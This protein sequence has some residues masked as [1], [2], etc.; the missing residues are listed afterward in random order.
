MR[1]RGRA[2]RIGGMALLDER[3]PGPALPPGDTA[4]TRTGSRR[5]PGRDHERRAV[6]P[7]CGARRRGWPWERAADALFYG[8]A[9][10]AVLLVMVRE[11][12]G[13]TLPGGAARGVVLGACA[14]VSLV[15]AVIVLRRR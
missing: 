7:G 12:T 5:A 9:A 13:T 15:V 3:R 14:V 2:A 10:S 11:L 4:A 6:P 8:V 1:G